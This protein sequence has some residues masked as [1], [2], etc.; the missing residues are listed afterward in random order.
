MWINHHAVISL[1]AGAD[2]VLLFLNI[3]L[4][5]AITAIP[6]PTELVAEGLARGG[7][8]AKIAAFVYSL[9][10][11]AA[12]IAFTPIALWITSDTS[13]LLREHLLAPRR[14]E[15]LR[16]FG[17]G[18]FFYLGLVG[19]S[20]LTPLVTLLGHGALAIYYCFDQ[21]RTRVVSS[22]GGESSRKN[23]G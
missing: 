13:G 14:G 21:L 18:T 7:R 20:F 2:R 6:S 3:G 5:M 19:L 17:I 11:L 9:V 16:G 22:P 10:M 23:L 15:L 8:D 12:A 4:L 1:A